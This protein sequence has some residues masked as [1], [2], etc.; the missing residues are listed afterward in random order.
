MKRFKE[1]FQKREKEVFV[2]LFSPMT[3]MPSRILLLTKRSRFQ[4]ERK[5][6]QPSSISGANECRDNRMRR[7]VQTSLLGLA[8]PWPPQAGPVRWQVVG[9]GGGNGQS[10]LGMSLR[11]V[12]RLGGSR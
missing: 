11:F 6:S 2:P 5:G 3:A 10:R 9:I 1:T 8:D 4:S 12:V 7:K